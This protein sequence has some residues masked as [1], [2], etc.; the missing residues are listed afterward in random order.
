MNYTTIDFNLVVKILAPENFCSF[1]NFF[2]FEVMMDLIAVI[3]NS[4]FDS[5]ILK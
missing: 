4:T 1:N 2:D 3:A 5:I